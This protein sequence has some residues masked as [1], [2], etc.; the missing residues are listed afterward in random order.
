MK[1]WNENIFRKNDIRG[2]YK[3]DFD[4][5]FIRALAFAFVRFYKQESL[6]QKKRKKLRVAVGHDCRLSSPEIA[7]HLTKSLRSAGAE[8]YF[9]GMTPSPLCFFASHFVKNITASIMVTASHN[10]PDFNGFKMILHKESLCDKKILQLKKL[11]R[12]NKLT[13]APSPG[14]LIR[15]NMDS[16]Y[17]SLLRKKLKYPPGRPLKSIAIDCGNGVSGPLAQKVFQALKWP[18]KIHWLYAQPDGRFPHHPPDPSVE[19]NLQ[20]LQ[21]IIK[22]KGCDFGAAFDGDGDRLVILRKNGVPLHGDELMSLFISDILRRQEKHPL[23]SK[24]KKFSVVA[25]VKCADWFFDFLTARQIPFIMG[26]SGHSLIRQKTRKKKA[27][28]GGEVSG[29]F[30]FLDDYFPID[31]G[32]YGLLRFIQICATAKKGPEKLLPSPRGQ[33]SP[34]I[35]RPFSHRHQAQKQLKNLK[36]FFKEKKSAQC[37]FVDGVRVRFPKK[38]WALARLSNTQNEWTFRFGG[39]TK[40]EREKIQKQFYRLLKIP[41]SK[42]KK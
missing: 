3:K 30:F 17:I 19:K 25:D 37:S 14:R 8:V 42:E 12:E 38:A 26:P 29:H 16:S 35:R 22:E 34:E 13:P 32:I 40:K 9:L 11:L 4:L 41:P 18:L 28:F 39:K 27:L 5:P 21:K 31:D 7:R 10:P 1:T 33:E 24:K 23:S 20:P 15:R 36:L 6:L 2:I